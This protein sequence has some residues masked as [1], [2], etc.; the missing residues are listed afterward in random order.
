MS[1][2]SSTAHHFIPKNKFFSITAACSFSF[3]NKEKT[4]QRFSLFIFSSIVRFSL[5]INY[6]Y[7]FL[8][9]S[10][11]AISQST[12]NEKQKQ[13][14]QTIDVFEWLA[15]W[16]LCCWV[17]GRRPIYRG[18]LSFQSFQRFP[19]IL[20]ARQLLLLYRGGQ[21][22]LIPF[23]CLLINE[24]KD[25]WERKEWMS[26]VG[27]KHITNNPQPTQSVEWRGSK[28]FNIPFISSI[29]KEK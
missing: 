16:W 10:L 8:L 3:N 12:S 7:N 26:L 11:P 5:S 18:E 1:C 14:A 6:R 13:L 4:S 20:L 29:N 27:Q 24:I 17:I 19:F 21:S 22:Q 15:W 2:R 23:V 25:W 28:Q 9:F